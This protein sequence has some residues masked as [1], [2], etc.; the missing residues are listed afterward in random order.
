MPNVRKNSKAKNISRK[1]STQNQTVS[2]NNTNN[3]NNKTLQSAKNFLRKISTFSKFRNSTTNNNTFLANN[4]LINA[5]TYNNNNSETKSVQN[6]ENFQNA[7]S[8]FFEMRYVFFLKKINSF[9]N[10]FY[11]II[12]SVI[13]KFN[14]RWKK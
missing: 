9:L 5:S 10:I 11:G 8:P 2:F 1:N 12:N 14:K 13:D 3:N 6:T 7:T 4:K